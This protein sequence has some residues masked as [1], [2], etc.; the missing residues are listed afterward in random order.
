MDLIVFSGKRY[1]ADFRKH[2]LRAA[3][4]DGCRATHVQCGRGVLVVTQGENVVAEYRGVRSYLQAFR[5]L[6]P[7]F[8]G[9]R[10]I[11]L[12]GT[13]PGLS[14][15]AL[16]ISVITVASCCSCYDVY[17]DFTYDATGATRCLRWMVDRYWRWVCQRVVI[18]DPNLAGRYPGALHLDNASHLSPQ[19][20]PPTSTGHLWTGTSRLSRCWVA[21]WPIAGSPS[22]CQISW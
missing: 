12:Y 18:L 11:V 6:R 15:F 20:K 13:G 7:L 4:A 21:P 5:L 10:T 14:L 19:R 22:Q 17:D 1:A 9:D 16:F 3:Q 8:H 2:L